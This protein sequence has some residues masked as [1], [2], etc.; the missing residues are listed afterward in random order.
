MS[1]VRVLVV[2]DDDFMLELVAEQLEQ[3]EFA[4][5]V[6]V[7]DGWSAL[8]FVDDEIARPDLIVFDLGL[9]G[10]HGTEMIRLLA[11]RGYRGGLVVMSGSP[12]HVL[13][14]AAEIG[15]GYGL[16]VVDTV[17]KPVDPAALRAAVEQVQRQL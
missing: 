6:P 16:W 14:A 8:A 11:D 7:S 5:V 13:A 1:R 3:I 12:G 10:L 15:E 2:D 17:A 9:T 4:D